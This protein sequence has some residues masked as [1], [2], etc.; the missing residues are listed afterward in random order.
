MPG[1]AVSRATTVTKMYISCPGSIYNLEGTGERDQRDYKCEKGLKEA[2]F[3]S[4]VGKAKLTPEG[5]K[6]AFAELGKSISG[7]TST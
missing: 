7:R 5:Q 6:R 1:S 3:I 2:I 4:C